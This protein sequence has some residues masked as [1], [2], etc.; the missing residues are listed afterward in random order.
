MG[1][2]APPLV[3][4]PRRGRGATSPFV[5]TRSRLR[6]VRRSTTRRPCQRGATDAEDKKDEWLLLEY[7]NPVR[8]TSVEVHE[9]FNPGAVAAIAILTP[10]GEEIE[11]WRNREVKATEEK[12]R[13]LQVDLPVGFEVERVKLYLA[14]DAVPGW[15]EI[16]A[17]GLR[18]DKGKLH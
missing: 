5:G 1:V 15:N 17:V 6:R 12:G 8:V 4:V 3:R 11:L 14:S 16:D 13:I 9:N 2:E 10:Q 18:D 7:A